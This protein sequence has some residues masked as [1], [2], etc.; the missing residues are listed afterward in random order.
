MRF[1]RCGRLLLILI[2][3]LSLG[4]WAQP[5]SQTGRG[6]P[7]QSA[8]AQQAGPQ[9][10][11]AAQRGQRGG[12]VGFYDYD[13]TAPAQGGLDPSA[14]PAESHQKITLDGG[15]LAYTTQ[16]GYLPLRNATTGQPEAFI[17]FTSYVKEGAGDPSA[18]PLVFFFG[19][20]PGVSAAWQEFGGLG[21]KRVKG[22]GEGTVPSAPFGWTDNPNTLLGAA[23]LVFVNPVGTGFSRPAAPSR[24]ANFW[25]TSGDIA[26]LAEFIRAFLAASDRRDS[27]LFLAGEDFGT[28]RVAGLA[29][30]LCDH[31]IPV[32]GAILL[33]LT[34]S[35]DAIA[36]DAQHL[37]L[38]PSLALASWAHKK[39]APEL[40]SLSAPALADE[41]R[42]F[43]SREYLHAL[44]KGDRMTA[45]ERS[46]V[47][48]SLVRYTGLSQLFIASNN[49]RIPLDRFT[50]ELLR[51]DRK[52][53]S[54]SDAR[55]AGF[56]PP[57]GGGG[58]GGFGFG[59]FAAPA[60]DYGQS[61]LAPG[62]QIAYEAYLRKE[63]G[64]T[65]GAGLF[66]LS[67]GGIGTFTSTGNDDAS[68]STAF[69][70]NPKLRLF[71]GIDYFDLASP[72]Y[73]AEFTLAHIGLSPDVRA[74]NIVV[75][76]YEAG[77]MPYLDAKALPKLQTDLVRFIREK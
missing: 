54:S 35:A 38:L 46:K 65:G 10:G 77:Q 20:A 32:A 41:A 60:V 12:G 13:A 61:S 62:F 18:R 74:R 40:Q 19:G 43:V 59:G 42:K 31:K 36:G 68:L 73:A 23:D 44:Y 52:A 7:P 30:Y 14:K 15:V 33:S 57:S 6:A 76:H 45:E 66:Y 2:L 28:G 3:S 22:I 63:L 1:P 67:S 16:A 24:G 55:V 53:V 58:R 49:L 9:G 39:L 75:S 50:A 34:P 11:A 21:P 27:P 64:F 51:A 56:V 5:A 72:F 69:V 26:S 37:T 25:T 71:V 29:S 17:F 48:A 4:G 8:A 70:R 47:Q